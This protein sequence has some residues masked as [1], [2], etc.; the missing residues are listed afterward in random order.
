MTQV[1]FIRPVGAEGPVKIGFSQMPQTRLAVFQ[2]WSPVL[3]EVVAVLPGGKELERRF[4]TRF[5]DQHSHCEWFHAGPELTAMIDQINA[6]AFSVDDLPPPTFAAPRP[7]KSRESVEAMVFTRQLQKIIDSGA[8]VPSDVRDA[9]RTYGLPEDEKAECRAIV[10]EFILS[11][12]SQLPS[13]CDAHLQL[14]S[15]SIL[16]VAQRVQPRSAT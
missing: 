14:R 5:R 3:L 9:A 16:S 13:P 1:Y 8:P 12:R 6:G 11:R 4:H 10:K 7:K 2:L 15:S